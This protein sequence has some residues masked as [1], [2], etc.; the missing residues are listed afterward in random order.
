MDSFNLSLLI[1][2]IVGQS[3]NQI[4]NIVLPI[5]LKVLGGLLLLLVGWVISIRLSAWANAFFE[6]SDLIEETIE[7]VLVQLIRFGVLAVSLVLV[8]QLFGVQTA[9]ILAL[10]SGVALA[11][12]LAVQGTLSN[13]AAGVMLLVLRP[14]KIGEWV[15]AAGEGGSVSRVGL[16]RTDIVT[17]NN[18]LVS[19]PN[20]AVFQA[21]IHNY[22]RLGRRRMTAV[23]GV[24]YDSDVDQ[25]C[26]ILRKVLADNPAWDSDPA[27]YL[28]VSNLGDFSVDISVWAWADGSVYFDAQANF[29]LEAKKALDAAGI[30]IPFP[31]HVEIRRSE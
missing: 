4:L 2:G 8:L 3:D 6:T 10:L 23:V 20:T 17:I 26:E 1:D 12:G 14:I 5:G 13:V 7:K 25:V 31:H 24:A 9:T 27:P 16:F 30:E 28:F 18:V 29:K 22:T 19:I 15:E 21:P 11:I